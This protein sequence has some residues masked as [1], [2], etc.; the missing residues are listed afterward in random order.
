[1][2]LYVIGTFLHE[3][4]HTAEI[5]ALGERQKD[6]TK[7]NIAVVGRDNSRNV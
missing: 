5:L 3:Y 1:M 6:I 4:Q 2:L 7:S